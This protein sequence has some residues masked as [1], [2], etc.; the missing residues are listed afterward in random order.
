MSSR[1]FDRAASYYD[2]TR[3]LPEPMATGGIQAI[4]DQLQTRRDARLLEVG[5]GTGRMAIPLLERGANLFG[6]DLSRP[7]LRR[8]HAKYAA[9]R[10]AQADAPR[11]PFATGHFDGLLTVHVMHLV[12]PW[13]EA[14]HEFARV[15]RPGGV[16]IN[17][18]NWHAEGD[19]DDRLRQYW[20]G[21]VDA[22]GGDWRRP[23][24]QSREELLD[25][26][27]AMGASV[28][29]VLVSRFYRSVAPGD[30]IAEIARRVHSDAWEVPE[31]VFER[32]LAELRAWATQEYGDLS[33]P[34]DVERRFLLDIVRF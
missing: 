7:M 4:L 9:A 30:V 34:R 33:R 21:R 31:A 17:S 25:G 27:R 11:L 1:T 18:W 16:Y 15:L 8:Q 12:G 22:H 23:G 14:L 19:V 3:D 6:C 26:L 20:R 5:A 13:R 28:E 2:E 10:L 24:V 32:S 29:V